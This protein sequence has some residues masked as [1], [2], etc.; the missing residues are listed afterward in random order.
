ML[1]T[2]PSPADAGPLGLGSA[3]PRRGGPLPP[4]PPPPAA[5]AAAAAAAATSA[6]P[7][8]SW[9]AS[10]LRGELRGPVPAL[11]T[12]DVAWGQTERQRV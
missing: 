3:S 9:L 7:V 5:A 6:A 12:A 4:L 11:P 2:I 1:P 8:P 10:H